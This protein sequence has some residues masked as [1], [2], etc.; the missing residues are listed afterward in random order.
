MAR[1][2]APRFKQ[3]RRLGVNV[4]GHP[5]AM[6]RA[7]SP[8]FAKRK[9]PTEYSK[10]LCEKQKLKAYYGILEKQ[11]HR[12]FE[13]AKKSSLMTGDALV[14]SLERRLDNVVYRIGFGNS[15]RLAR[16]LVSHG[17]ILVNGKKVDIPSYKVEVGDVI[18]LKESSQKNEHFR[19]C[20]LGHPLFNVPYIEKNEEAFSG[21]LTRLPERSEIPVEVNDQY[22]V[23]YYSK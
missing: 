13:K 16:Q 6:K 1:N 4:C 9:K 19:D 23:E 22:V 8:A 11:L 17:H 14:I 10:Q 18:S 5:K 20:F 3:C 7:G 21:K 12:Y 2:M 15:I